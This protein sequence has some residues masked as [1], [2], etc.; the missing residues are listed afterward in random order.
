MPTRYSVISI[1]HIF[2]LQQPVT[3]TL[4]NIIIADNITI[5]YSYVILADNVHSKNQNEVHD[6]IKIIQSWRLLEQIIVSVTCCSF[7]PVPDS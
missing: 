7:L 4:A 5:K 3:K 2:E 1:R 6:E